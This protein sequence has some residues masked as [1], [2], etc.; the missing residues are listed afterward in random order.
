MR[1]LGIKSFLFIETNIQPIR[2]DT[3]TMHM[4]P[5]RRAL[6]K[7]LV[8]LVILALVERGHKAVQVRAIFLAV[9]SKFQQRI[10]SSSD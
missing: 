1:P 3:T 10:G 7:K 5:C 8:I 6:E 4:S 2:M 9:K